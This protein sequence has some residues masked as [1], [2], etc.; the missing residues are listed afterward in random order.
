M[1]IRSD[2]VQFLIS[3]YIHMYWSTC[4]LTATS[5]NCIT[6]SKSFYL[7]GIRSSSITHVY[8]YYYYYIFYKDTTIIYVLIFFYYIVIYHN[9]K[10]QPARNEDKLSK[11]Y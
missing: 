3:T 6:N 8:M 11:T 5:I 9:D 1:I 4:T 10:A 2:S 7:N